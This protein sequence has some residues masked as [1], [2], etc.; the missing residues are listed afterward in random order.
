[1][2]KKTSDFA[3]MFVVEKV[4]PPWLIY[5]G[6]FKNVKNK[7]SRRGEENDKASNENNCQTARRKANKHS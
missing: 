2:H 3:Y 7:A 1:M 4:P 5:R 6:T